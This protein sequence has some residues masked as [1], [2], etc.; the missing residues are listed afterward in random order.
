M[1]DL[2]IKVLALW[3]PSCIYYT[4]MM[5]LMQVR[6]VRMHRVLKFHDCLQN[7]IANEP[8]VLHYWYQ[9]VMKEELK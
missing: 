8:F 9:F 6:L 2:L 7:T 3:L 4:F 5:K 1:S